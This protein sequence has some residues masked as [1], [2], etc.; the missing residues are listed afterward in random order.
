VTAAREPFV[1]WVIY[2]RP[3]DHPEHYVL[4]RQFVRSSA[5]VAI[6]V[7]LAPHGVLESSAD[8]LILI[9]RAA[10]LFPSLEATRSALPPGLHRLNRAPGD[11]PVIVETWM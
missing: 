5:E 9:D 7:E 2:C 3:K 1:L 4:R 8:P 10:L 6:P 11:D